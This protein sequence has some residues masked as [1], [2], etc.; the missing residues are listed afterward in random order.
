M[1]D[2]IK[3]NDLDVRSEGTVVQQTNKTYWFK[4]DFGW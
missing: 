2:D 4:D 1:G 3:I